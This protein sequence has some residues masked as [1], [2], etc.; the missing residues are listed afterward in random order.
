MAQEHPARSAIRLDGK[1][2]IVT[3]AARGLGRAMAEGL[4][5]AGATVVFTDIDAAALASAARAVDG[6]RGCG[7][8]ARFAGDI[9]VRAECERVVAET[10]K[11][12]GALHIL[13]NNAG[14]GPALLETSPQTKSL[15]FW[16]AD[17]DAWRE[18][19]VTNVNGTFL[20][21]R[22]AA[23][24]MVEAG[25][26]RIINITTSL[27]TMQRRHNSPYGVSKAA[28]EAET[29]IWAKDLDGTG[30][31]VN[32]LIPGGAADTE[33]VHMA[34]RKELAALGRALLPPS[35]MVA[36]IVWLA[37]PLSD[38][39]TGARFVGKLWDE[40]LPPNEAAAKA[41]EA[42]VLL[43]LPPDAR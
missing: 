15:K 34:S 12:F 22:S 32:S 23:P 39:V 36:P 13:V 26:G 5:R 42:S 29:L 21:A 2:A 6:Q 14:K 31:T 18:I 24:V 43:A 19:I 41:R 4:V 27:A 9:T 1:V 20:M 35:V 16:E 7:P 37:S 40:R 25:W 30:V 3:G 17:P 8:V 11:R 38:G 33:F 10:V 28:I